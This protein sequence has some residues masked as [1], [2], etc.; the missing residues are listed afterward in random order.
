MSNLTRPSDHPLDALA[1][2]DAVVVWGQMPNDVVLT[3]E[4]VLDSLEPLER[5]ARQALRNRA[6]GIQPSE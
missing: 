2:G 3:P 1:N 5:A 6:L 4:A